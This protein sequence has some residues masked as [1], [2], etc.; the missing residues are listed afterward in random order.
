MGYVRHTF[1][2]FNL[3][4]FVRSLPGI[5]AESSGSFPTYTI[6]LDS[7]RELEQ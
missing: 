3:L 6:N 5:C 4:D 2:I 1:N 7:T